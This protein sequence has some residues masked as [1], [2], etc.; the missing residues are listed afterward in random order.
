MA[1]QIHEAHRHTEHRIWDPDAETLPRDGIEALQVERLREL[2]TRVARVPFYRD[3]FA[4]REIGP[5]SIRSLADIRRLPLTTKDDLRRQQPL[6][7]LAVPRK[8]LARIHGSSGTTGRPTF[9]AYTARDLETWSNLCARFL[10]AGGLRP[11]HTAQVA[12]GYGLFTGGFGLHYGIERVGAA[13]IPAAAGNTRRQIEIMRDLDP[14]VLI[15]TPSYALT[16]ADSARELGID[17]RSLPI[18]FGHFGGEPWT[19]DMRREIEDQLDIAAFNNY[20]LSEVIG[21][22]VSGECPERTGMHI[23]EDHFLV[24]CLDPETLEPVPEGEPGELVITTLTREAMPLIRYRTRDIARLYREPC[25]CGRRTTRMSRVTGRTDDMLIIRGVNVFPS[26]IEEALLR[27][28]GTTPHYL[29]EVSRPGTL[30]EVHVK[31]EIRPEIFSDRMDR[32]QALCE[33]ISREINTV[34]GIRAHVDLVEP[35][36]IERF[37]GKAKRVLDRRNLN[38]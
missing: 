4:H 19:E 15:C 31:V 25:A 7:F 1:A 38:E 32:M 35:R 30:D 9:V 36:S 6:G 29:I 3:H 13:I 14:E 5:H 37:L 20:G 16:I 12:F 26:Q 8:D 27:V 34:A 17:P 33:R 21:P 2:V 22:G 11:E 28:E 23:Q 24:E 10:V 18:R